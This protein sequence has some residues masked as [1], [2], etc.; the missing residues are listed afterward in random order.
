MKGQVKSIM[1]G[2]WYRTAKREDMIIALMHLQIEAM[3]CLNSELNDKYKS[4][5]QS[6]IDAIINEINGNGE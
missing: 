6:I 4:T 2:N 5:R 3:D 1:Q